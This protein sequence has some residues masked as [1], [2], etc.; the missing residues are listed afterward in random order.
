M[1]T[2]K[3]FEIIQNVRL[4]AVIGT[5]CVGVLA[6][7]YTVAS[8]LR[9]FSVKQDSLSDLTATLL[10]GVAL[11]L[12]ITALLCVLIFQ[13]FS[14]FETATLPQAIRLNEAMRLLH[15]KTNSESLAT[16]KFYRIA[17][18]R[19]QAMLGDGVEQDIPCKRIVTFLSPLF[20][21]T[22]Q[23]HALGSNNYCCDYSQIETIIAA[24]KSNWG[25]A[26]EQTS[27]IPVEVIALER[28]IDDL[29]A[30]LK[31]RTS[32]YTAATGR[33]GRLKISM[34]KVETH[35]AILVELAS[36][37]TSTVKP[38]YNITEGK[39]RDKYLAIAKAYGVD[40]APPTYIEIFRKNMPADIINWGGAPK[41][42]K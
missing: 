4:M 34:E 39:I 3:K 33:E 8:L 6:T 38:P 41:Q 20:F 12:L 42:G 32:N 17:V 16:L 22:D 19:T 21:R 37:V 15:A 14:F 9:Y 27:E 35:M 18:Y 23:N 26:V 36:H 10:G 11:G 1:F 5:G 13:A 40:E 25:S 28:K 31:E 7:S 2:S 29:Q 24:N 30:K